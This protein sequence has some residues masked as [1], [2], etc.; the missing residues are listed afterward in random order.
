MN[1]SLPESDHIINPDGSVYHLKL[2]PGEV[3]RKI[4]TVGD[5]ERV[6]QVARYFDLIELTR[7]NR[8]FKTITGWLDDQRL[9]VISTGIGTDNIDIVM[10]ELDSLFNID[11]SSR[12]PK[13]NITPLQFFRLGTSGSIHDDV[14]MDTCLVSGHAYGL[15]SLADFYPS[16]SGLNSI[17]NDIK[18][19]QFKSYLTKADDELL[20]YFIPFFK[21]GITLTIPGF[22]HPQGRLTR[23]ENPRVLE[24][25]QL[26]NRSTALG[27]ITNME[28]ETSGIYLLAEYYGHQAISLNAIL[29]NRLHQTYTSHPEK[30]IAKM[31]SQSIEI[32]LTIPDVDIS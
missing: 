15:D 11:F 30:T 21:V 17:E 31:I 12:L 23:I 20:K 19:P 13:S 26:F 32:I 3:A 18:M 24:V 9:S 7:Q 8:E 2:K 16:N 29:A 4:I 10:T 28:M 5:P 14:E 22:Y 25:R 27:K 6:D 1:I